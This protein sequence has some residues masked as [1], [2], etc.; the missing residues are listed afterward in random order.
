MH[1]IKI[2]VLIHLFYFR[3]SVKTGRA[4]RNATFP[5]GVAT[6]YSTVQ[7]SATTAIET[8]PVKCADDKA[9]TNTDKANYTAPVITTS[10]RTA[11]N[12]LLSIGIPP[13]SPKSPTSINPLD[14][15]R[16]IGNFFAS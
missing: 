13:Q 12:G 6:T 14:S 2:F 5:G 4:K 10:D 11:D 3:S 1:R 8:P 16:N 15:P 7:Y 9:D